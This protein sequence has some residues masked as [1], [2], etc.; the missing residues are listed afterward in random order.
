M[1]QNTIIM[2]VNAASD[3]H[4]QFQRQLVMLDG[5]TDTSPAALTS[6][7]AMALEQR[8]L[9]LVLAHA[10]TDSDLRINFEEIADLWM[11]THILAQEYAVIACRRQ[12]AAAW[13]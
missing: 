5:R 4:T 13:A 10:H 6:F 1:D 11:R 9:L 12:A 3:N 2:L 7:A 8:Q